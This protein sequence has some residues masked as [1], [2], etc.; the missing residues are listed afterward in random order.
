LVAEDNLI[1]QRVISKVLQRVVPLATVTVVGNG[2]LAVQAATCQP[3]DL[4][5]MDIHMPGGFLSLALLLLAWCCWRCCC[6]PGAGLVLLLLCC[7]WC[8]HL[9]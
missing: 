6:W 9:G 8:C 1:N 3:Y 2:A 5:L 4:C 7:C